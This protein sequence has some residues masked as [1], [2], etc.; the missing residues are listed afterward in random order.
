MFFKVVWLVEAGE[1][2]GTPLRRETIE[3]KVNFN[4]QQ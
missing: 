3:K 4:C 1:I 2:L